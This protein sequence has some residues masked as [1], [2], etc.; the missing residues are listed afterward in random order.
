MGARGGE[1]AADIANPRGS[2]I[3]CRFGIIIRNNYA[4]LASGAYDRRK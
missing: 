4:L 3:Q 2:C 1:S